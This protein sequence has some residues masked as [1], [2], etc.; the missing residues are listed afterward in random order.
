MIG[1]RLYETARVLVYDPVAPNRNGT[2]ASL[3][4]LGYRN[5]ETVPALDLLTTRLQKDSPDLLLAEV[6]GAEVETC[7]LVQAIRQGRLGHNPFIVVVVTTWRRDG[8]IIGQVL[9]S[10]ADD[11]VARPVSATALGE[12]IRLLIERRKGFV[13]TSDYIGP[14]RRRNTRAA[15]PGVECMETPNPLKLRTLDHL[16][17]EEIAREIT[18]SVQ[19][20]KETLN[21]EKLRRDAV[22]LCLQW[23]MLEQR[24]PGAR[25]FC[26]ILPRI[27]R[28]VAEMKRRVV[29]TKQD[30][31][32][33]WCDSIIQ[34]IQNLTAL[35]ERDSQSEFAPDYR[36]LL[37][38]LGHAS[39]T[40]GHMF[41]AAE[42]EPA[43]LVE[44]DRIVAVRTARSA[45]A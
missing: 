3:F 1:K 44:L 9:N 11:L 4:S 40:L 39:L 13:V 12:R 38:L 23:R 21:L 18:E 31:A 32:Q 41:A 37:K 25:D 10:G 15:E 35:G 2:R 27:G 17:E 33:E 29:L 14:D 5:V 30:A 43:R 8:S 34:S 16:S 20:G 24:H 26:E 22:Q 19:K 28:L 7:A 45:A 36:S 42:V 6:A